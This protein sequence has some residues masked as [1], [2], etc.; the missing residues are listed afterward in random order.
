MVLLQTLV[1]SVILSMIAVMV[2]QWVLGR[3]L[4]ASRSFKSNLTI[5]HVMGVTSEMMSQA[6]DP[7]TVADYNVLIQDASYP[8]RVCVHVYMSWTAPSRIVVSADEDLVSNGC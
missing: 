2:M 8:Q 7:D 4:I 5:V 6:I 3:Y 1:M